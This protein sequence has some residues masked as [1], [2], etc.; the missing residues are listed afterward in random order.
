VDVATAQL[1]QL[2]QPREYTGTTQ[3][4]QE[5]SLRSQV[6]GQLVSLS[7]N[8]GDQVEQG[9]TLA[10]VNS[11]LLEA[12]VV[13]AQAELASRQA[14]VARLQS[15]VSD[16]RTQVEQARLRLRQAERDATRF[17]Q[18][19]EAGAGTRQQAEQ[20]RTDAQAAA[21]VVRS[22]EEQV[23]SRLKEVA[24]AESRVTAQQAVIAQ[25]QERLGFTTL[26][27]PI[28]GYVLAKTSEAGNLVQPGGEIV[29]LGDFSRIKVV[30]QVSDRDVA[31]IRQGQTAQVRLDAVPNQVFTGTVER[32]TPAAN[33]TSRLAPVEIVIPNPGGQNGSGSLARVT[34][35]GGARPTVIVPQSALQS[36]RG[37]GNR[38]PAQGNASSPGTPGA[39]N[40]QGRSSRPPTGA[41]KP[42]QTRGTLF[43]VEGQGEQATVA[44]R[45]V[46]LGDRA[47]GRVEVRSG[48]R[49]GERYVVRAGRPLKDGD[50]VRLSVLSQN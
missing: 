49:P 28:T 48:L 32:I 8:V 18:L 1:G 23:A 26:Q 7:V 11:T 43:V 22:A 19:A 12:G 4:I 6:E 50:S 20:A 41:A 29:K 25:A 21:Q 47:D 14:E 2:Q 27:A 45:S 46:A 31:N 9:Q 42:Q 13:E 16:A 36:D 3:P 38:G 35:A 15:Q 34:F 37:A 44:A 10:Q 17:T 24:A 5:V 30:V 33:P 40:S 39:T